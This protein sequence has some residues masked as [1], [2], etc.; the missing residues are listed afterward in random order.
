MSDTIRL[1]V[2][3]REQTG[4][5]SARQARREGLVPGVIYGGDEPSVAIAF[6]FNEVLKAINS[7]QFLGSMIEIVHDGKP[8]KAFTKDV[9]FHPVS[10]MPMHVDLFR[11]TNRTIIEV[12]VP[13]TFVGEED[14]PGLKEGGTLNVVR[15]AVEVACPAGSIPESFEADVSKLEIG[16]SLN[17][18]DIT[19]PEG[20]KPVIDDRDFTVASVVATRAAVEEETDEDVA[21]DAVPATEQD[22]GQGDDEPGEDSE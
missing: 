12:E 7:G 9:D 11:V 16:D 5:G 20:V 17:I 10:D 22:A 21:A 18:S 8:Q 14:S 3:V 13:V 6:K 2:T 1:D 15:Y 4:T 19:L